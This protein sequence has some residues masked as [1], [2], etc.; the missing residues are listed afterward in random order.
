M[1]IHIYNWTT[2]DINEIKEV[3]DFIHIV[4][5]VVCKDIREVDIPNKNK[6]DEHYEIDF[7]HFSADLEGSFSKEDNPLKKQLEIDIPRSIIYNGNDIVNSVEQIED[8]HGLYLTQ[9][10]LSLPFQFLSYIYSDLHIC[11]CLKNIEG[12]VNNAIYKI[13]ENTISVQK[14]LRGIQFDNDGCYKVCKMFDI[15]L[16]IDILK[17]SIE[18]TLKNIDI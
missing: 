3:D 6:I 18:M 8:Q 9:A 11:D 17:N 5:E 16:I 10:T 2:I 12:D 14:Q 15:T 4:N 13:E 7:A 1:H